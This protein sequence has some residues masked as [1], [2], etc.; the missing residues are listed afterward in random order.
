MIA[1]YI[2]AAT[3]YSKA[4]ADCSLTVV[5]RSISNNGVVHP[6]QWSDKTIF[7]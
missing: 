7:S 3:D 6:Q 1:D 2:A 5:Y 4:G